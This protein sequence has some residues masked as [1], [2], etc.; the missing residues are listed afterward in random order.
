M[1]LILQ[2]L[3][4]LHVLLSLAYVW[5]W[6]REYGRLQETIL[7][8]VFCLLLPFV[9]CLLYTSLLEELRAGERLLQAFCQVRT[10]EKIKGSVR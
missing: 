6:Y 5:D 9:G 4:V 1:E 2:I 3:L 8:L 7:R 10:V